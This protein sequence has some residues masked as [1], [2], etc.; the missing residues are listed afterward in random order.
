MVKAVFWAVLCVVVGV[1]F[2]HRMSQVLSGGSVTQGR[3]VEMRVVG[4]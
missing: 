3:S 1:D 4:F 2:K